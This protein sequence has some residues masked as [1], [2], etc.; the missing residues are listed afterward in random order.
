MKYLQDYINDSQTAV[1]DKAGAFFA[2]SDKQYEEQKSPDKDKL[3]YTHL[4]GGLI[5]PKD[6]AK[7]LLIDL[8]EVHK[9]GIE[10]D[11]AENGIEGIIK[12]ELNNYE[13]Y[14]TRDITS[15]VE[16]LEPYGITEDQVRKI[17]HNQ[18]AKVTN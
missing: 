17:F 10:Q 4:F 7:Q 15:T 5:C 2:F 16:A 11:I 18:N 14:Y 1:I 13:A 12:R 6:T 8:A 3:D 9:V